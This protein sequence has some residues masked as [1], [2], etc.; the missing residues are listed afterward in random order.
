MSV[1][2]AAPPTRIWDRLLTPPD[3]ELTPDHARYLLRLGFTPADHERMTELCTKN[4]AN[5]LSPH[6]RVELDDYV[7]VSLQLARLHSVA[8]VALR[9]GDAGG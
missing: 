4:S 5:T 8:R 3:G 7:L 9:R 1:A 6:E 2:V